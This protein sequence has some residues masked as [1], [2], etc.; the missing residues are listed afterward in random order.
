MFWNTENFRYTPI[1]AQNAQN[2]FR[3]L[4]LAPRYPSGWQY[5]T[6]FL[7]PNKP[8]S[9]VLEK[10]SL[11]D[12]PK[13]L[14]LSYRWGG[15]GRQILVNG[16]PFTVTDNLEIALQHLRKDWEPL[17]LWV[18]A[19]CINQQDTE[20]KTQQVQQMTDIYRR[21][22]QVLIWLGPAA[23][24]SDQVMDNLQLISQVCQRQDLRKSMR[25]IRA[26]SSLA[27][28]RNWWSR[29]WVIQELCVPE[30]PI[31]VCGNKRVSYHDFSNC[32]SLL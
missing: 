31:F 3:L 13:Y 4:H 28:T 21:A 15:T 23:D 32:S 26:A 5:A 11:K 24:G 20:E 14:A 16:K 30:L 27:S 22:K 29:T 19:I 9:C 8:I 6:S 25:D 10:V 12:P 1:N 7:Y 17:T 2:E 18:D